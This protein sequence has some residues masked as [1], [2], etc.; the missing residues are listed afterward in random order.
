M[1]FILLRR[2]DGRKHSHNPE[3]ILTIPTPPKLATVADV[4]VAHGVA[5]PRSLRIPDFLVFQSTTL[6]AT[7]Y[8]YHYHQTPQDFA[9]R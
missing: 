6:T 9:S 2:Y 3:N 7:S 1:S 4:Q 8:K 5:S